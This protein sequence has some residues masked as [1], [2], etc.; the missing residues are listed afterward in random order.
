MEWNT[1]DPT[2]EGA[3][4]FWEIDWEPKDIENSEETD[5]SE[6]VEQYEQDYQIIEEN[7]ELERR[8]R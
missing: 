7:D 4:I 2:D 8:R 1:Y 6:E 3:E 5:G